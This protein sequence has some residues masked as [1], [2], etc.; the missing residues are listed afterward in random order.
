[1]VNKDPVILKVSMPVFSEGDSEIPLSL[2]KQGKDSLKD[3][4]DKCFFSYSKFS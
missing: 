3:F 2:R 4:M 1:M